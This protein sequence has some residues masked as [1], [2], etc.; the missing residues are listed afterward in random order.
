[1]KLL[2]AK[3]VNVTQLCADTR[4][5]TLELSQP[6]LFSP[7]QFIMLNLPQGI[8]RA[9][10]ICSAPDGNRLELCVNKVGKASSYLFSLS[11][12]AKLDIDGPYGKFV[13]RDTK[14]D[15]LFVATGTGIAPIRSILTSMLRSGKKQ[16][17]TLIFGEKTFSDLIFYDEFKSFEQAYKN[18]TYVP[19]LSR[20][21]SDA[22]MGHV[23]DYVKAFAKTSLDVYVCGVKPMVD[24]VLAILMSEGVKNIYTERFV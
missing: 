7:G 8:R 17:I 20:E 9:Y 19:I 4:S 12:G 10:S 15:V 16:K 21:A 23:Q 11:L 24:D 2:T 13:L 18:F 5:F 14:N 22:K 3:L 6:F 1:M